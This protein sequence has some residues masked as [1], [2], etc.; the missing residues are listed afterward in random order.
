MLI[1]EGP[2]FFFFVAILASGFSPEFT[3]I[4][5]S[6]VEMC[7][8]AELLI[9]YEISMIHENFFGMDRNFSF[10]LEMLKR[11]ADNFCL[12]LFVFLPP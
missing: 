12:S 8:V 3:P 4:N 7:F 6:C 11:L 9:C 5:I 10:L 1:I 2:Y